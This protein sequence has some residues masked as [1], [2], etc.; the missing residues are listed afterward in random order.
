[1]SPIQFTKSLQKEY[2]DLYTRMEIR[3]DKLSVVESNVDKILQYKSRY[4]A[5]GGPLNIPWYFVGIIHSMESGQSF[6]RHLHN[7]DPLTAR[8]IQ[9]PS[10][11]PKTGNPPF[12]WE[13]S[14]ADA[15]KYHDLDQV[16]E[17][18]LTRILFEFERYNGWG[19]RLYHQH[20]Y[21]PYLWSCSNQYTKGKYIADGT[22]SETA[23]SQQIGAV[24]LLRRLEERHEIPNFS[25][26]PS[27]NKPFFTYS[28]QKEPRADDLQRFLNT[29]DG[30]TL[31]VD[32]APGLKTSEAVKK[33]FGN[34]LPNTPE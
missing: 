25:K 5:V 10:G 8:T 28:N 22:W 26:L 13:V 16:S 15:L 3:L 18:T 24:V 23:V 27:G 2:E 29:F 31:L 34:Y 19:Y 33:L 30:I 21:S 14:A 32:G 20:V 9:V 17:W 11:R 7:G 1:M 12:T 4:Q 6:S